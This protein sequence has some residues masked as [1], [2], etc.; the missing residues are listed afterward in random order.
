MKRRKPSRRD[1]ESLCIEP[2][3]EDGADPREYFRVRPNPDRRKTVQLA[4]QVRRTLE[5]V[6]AGV[7]RE[8]VLLDLIVRS[9]EPAPDSTHFVV[10]VTG[11][12]PESEALEALGR[13]ASWLRSEVAASI[14]RRK[15]P[16]LTY[17]FL[18]G[19]QVRP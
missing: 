3:A 10:I 18:P 17:R 9:V 2:G 4:G 7:S 19:K 13:A 16:L 6:M 1:L 8:P 11:E 5:L 12:V 14:H 15:A